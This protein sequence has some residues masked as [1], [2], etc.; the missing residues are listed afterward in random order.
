MVIR[1]GGGIFYNRFS[2]GSTL[3]SRRF[4]GVNELQFAVTEEARRLRPPTVAEQNAEAVRATYAIL[5]SFN[6][7]TAPP[8]T[9][10]AATQQTVW[11]VDPNLQIPTVYVLGT[12]IERQLPRNITM[13]VGVYAIRIRH[14]IRAR[15]INA[16]LPGTIIPQ[17]S[18]NGI[19]PD[20]TRG[21]VYRFEASGKFDQRQ[22]FI[23]LN[24]R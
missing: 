22:M 8:V 19:R 4:N 15:D 23:G 10:V 17:I 24:S 3:I 6:P 13:V 7:A 11:Q 9:D 20:P 21:E 18:P 1:G 14:V 12:Q 2:E 16:P 5:N